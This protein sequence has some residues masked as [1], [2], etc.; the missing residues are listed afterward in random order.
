MNIEIEIL[1]EK[2]EFE[3]SEKLYKEICKFSKEHNISIEEAISKAIMYSMSQ[4]D[5]NDL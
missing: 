3:I 1:D 5:I 2:L 4:E